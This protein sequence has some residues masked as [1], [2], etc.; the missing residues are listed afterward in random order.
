MRE[1]VHRNMRNDI[2]TPMHYLL[3]MIDLLLDSDLTEKQRGIAEAARTSGQELRDSINDTLDLF[4]TEAGKLSGRSLPLD[5][6]TLPLDRRVLDE[7]RAF[8]GNGSSGLAERLISAYIENSPKFIKELNETAA[9]GDH[10]ALQMTAHTF[11][12]SS[13][14]LGAMTLA[15]LCDDLKHCDHYPDNGV[16]SELIPRIEAEHKR[17]V[18]ALQREL[19]CTEP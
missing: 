11:R 18:A 14:S 17:V 9:N 2:N 7:I 5:S 13:L 8:H 1:H 15:S 16:V 6:Q 10:D 12:C 19:H 3:R 4:E